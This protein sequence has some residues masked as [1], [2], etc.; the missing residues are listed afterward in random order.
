LLAEARSVA[1]GSGLAFAALF[2]NNSMVRLN[3]FFR[4]R[5][6]VAE[7]VVVESRGFD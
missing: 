2:F 4:A 3:L 7:I 1:F 6:I 5:G